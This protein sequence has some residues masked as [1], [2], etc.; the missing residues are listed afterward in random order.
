M[1]LVDWDEGEFDSRRQGARRLRRSAA[2]TGAGRRV[3]DQ[4][5]ARR[6]RRDAVRP[7]R[8]GTTARRCWTG[9]R[10]STTRPAPRSPARLDVQRVIRPQGSRFPR[11]RRAAG[12]RSVCSVGDPVTVLPSGRSSVVSGIQRFGRDDRCRRGRSGDHGRRWP[13]RSTLPA[14]TCW[15]VGVALVDRGGVGPRVLDD[16]SARCAPGSRY[17]FKHGTRVGRGHGRRGRVSARPPHARADHRR[18]DR[19]QRPGDGAPVA[20]RADRR[21][22]P[23]RSVAKA[24]G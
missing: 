9:S 16:R 15:S 19:A 13:T 11:L 24:V 7:T 3:P 6:Q 20:Q 10:T 2:D 21:R 14:A 8:R 22:R 12:R 17:W 23:T 5:L 18:P 1:D 4:R